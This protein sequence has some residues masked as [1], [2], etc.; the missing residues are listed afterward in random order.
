VTEFKLTIHLHVVTKNNVQLQFPSHVITVIK[1]KTM[2]W[3]ENVA[4]MGIVR[5]A[6]ETLIEDINERGLLGDI[7][8]EDR[9][10]G[11]Q[12]NGV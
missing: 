4:C 8:I 2:R 1:S 9:L 11:P 7:E 10:S 12:R 6:S 3:S 5:N